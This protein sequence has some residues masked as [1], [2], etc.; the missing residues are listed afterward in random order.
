MPN[1]GQK[2]Q[3]LYNHLDKNKTVSVLLLRKG[4]GK[5][6]KGEKMSLRLQNLKISRIDKN[7][8]DKSPIALARAVADAHYKRASRDAEKWE[9]YEELEKHRNTE[10]ERLGGFIFVEP[11][12]YNW[13]GVLE[14]EINQTAEEMAELVTYKPHKEILTNIFLTSA[15]D[16]VLDCDSKT[17]SRGTD[18]KKDCTLLIKE[19][20]QKMNKRIKIYKANDLQGFDLVL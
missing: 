17:G 6:K 12:F 19:L 8:E 13:L 20:L 11:C 2:T 10:A 14:Q 15:L 7:G 18:H 3:S 1:I 16:L 5:Y 9:N 4:N